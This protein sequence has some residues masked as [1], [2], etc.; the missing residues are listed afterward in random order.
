MI[1]KI[2]SSTG[3]FS[4]VK[5]NT[6]KMNKGEGELMKI[7]NFPNSDNNLNL[8]PEEVKAYLKAHSNTNT[9]IKN[10]QFHATIS[11]KGTE[12]DKYQ[13]T[14]LAIKYLDKMGY[15]EN[16]YIIVF[17]SDTDNNHVHIVSSRV[18][19]FG[20]KINDSN[21]R[22]RSQNIRAELMKE[23]NMKEDKDLKNLL[24]YKYQNY[25]QLIKLLEHQGYT[26][27]KKENALEI[28]YNGENKLL[29]N[30]TDLHF[31][32]PDKKRI[33]QLKAIF[34]KYQ[35][36]HNTDVIPIYDKLKG[37]RDSNKIIGY[38]SEYGDFLKE[39]F[40]L[41]LVYHFSENR[42]PFGYT[43]FDHS[44]KNIL[45]GSDILPL[46]MILKKDVERDA[47]HKRNTLLNKVNQFNINSV[48]EIRLLSKYF[49]VPEYLISVNNKTLN[50]TDVFFYKNLLD[51][52]FEK[53]NWSDINK[54][55]LIP[56]YQ[57]GDLYLIDK[58]NSNLL[59][60]DDFLSESI[61]NEYTH[62]HH[63]HDLPLDLDLG[64]EISDDQDDQRFHK[65]KKRT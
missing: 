13:L 52:F 32:D 22:H 10:A 56:I 31:T 57:D 4:A 14:D 30:N 21:E 12:L 37:G 58:I 46:K 35:K 28:K 64:L 50:N 48:N 65:K 62:S 1:I 39:M 3:T 47:T 8:S 24:S 53:N 19:N 42:P 60:A 15:S 18:D 11:A 43:I 23:F 36:Q 40:G 20:K 38:R 61:I 41:E 7:E 5:Y 33:A 59:K 17:H 44:Q 29:L 55:N 45:K 26:I 34:N 49:K 54:I 51:N 63:V 27:I 6:N 2:L 9:R 25:N 16:P